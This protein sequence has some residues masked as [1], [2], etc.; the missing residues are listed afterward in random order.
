MK[1]IRDISDNKRMVKLA[2]I[3]VRSSTIGIHILSYV[4]FFFCQKKRCADNI[5]HSFKIK[6]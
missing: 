1:I 3:I 5:I 6:V 4:F 2:H